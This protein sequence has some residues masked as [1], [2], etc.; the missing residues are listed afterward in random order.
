MAREFWQYVICV[1]LSSVNGENSV[2]SVC[3]ATS[4]SDGVFIY[5]S[6]FLNSSLLY[7]QS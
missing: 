1:S 5:S 3:G 4:I 6:E 2:S 7:I